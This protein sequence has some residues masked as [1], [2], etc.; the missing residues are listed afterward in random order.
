[1][2]T[3]E[4]VGAVTVFASL[5]VDARDRLARVPADIALAPGEYA[6]DQGDDRA[7]FAVLEGRIEP[8]KLVDGIES[9]VG[10]RH[11]GDIFGEVPI[12]LGTVFP[13]GFRAAEQ[14]RVMRIE[15][16]DYHAVAAIHP[17]VAK[18][19]GKLSRK[20]IGGS[21][22]LQSL[23]LGAPTAPGGCARAPLGL[24][25]RGGAALPRS[26]PDQLRLDRSR[27]AG[28]WRPVGRTPSS[29]GGGRS[30][31]SHRRRHDRRAAPASPAGRAA[32]PWH[33]GRGGR[34]RRGD[35]RC[36]TCGPGR[37]RLRRV[38]GPEDDRGRAGGAEGGR[39]AR[40]REYE[41]FLGFPSG[42]SG[43]ELAGRALKQARRLGAEILVT[44]TIE[45]DRRESPAGASGRR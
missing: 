1:M 29:G 30:R 5:E 15:P 3:A 24:G 20:R 22:G 41:N 6:A 4:E 37:G 21:G 19:I 26:Q 32:R 39:P 34:V 38:G 9:V 2:V 40:R 18:E 13:V 45:R 33:G 27:R 28:C 12:V 8:V 43:D 17:D 16:H 31:R 14:S 42:V 36:R 44:R 25:L 7:L 23:G 11:P 35:C 10:E